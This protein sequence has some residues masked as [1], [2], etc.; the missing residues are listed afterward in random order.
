METLIRTNDPV[1][2]SVIQARLDEAQITFLLGDEFASS[3]DGSIGA[4]PRR[5]LVA[6][7]DLIPAQRA[8]QDVLDK[9]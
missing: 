4:I 8:I 2:I 9:Q 5:I 7:E 3:M 6:E 1:V